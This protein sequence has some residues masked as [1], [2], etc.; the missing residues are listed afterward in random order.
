MPDEPGDSEHKSGI[1]SNGEDDRWAVQFR[2]W[3][4]IRGI[5]LD[6]AKPKPWWRS[7]LWWTVWG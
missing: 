7:W 3:E 2:P 1:K 5:E 6:R 4:D